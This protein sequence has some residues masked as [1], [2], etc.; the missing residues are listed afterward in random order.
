MEKFNHL[1]WSS[2]AWTS[3]CVKCVF[4]KL[5]TT[6]RSPLEKQ[7]GPAKAKLTM[8]AGSLGYGAPFFVETDFWKIIHN[9]DVKV[10]LYLSTRREG[11]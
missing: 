4:K 5:I 7:T 6:I 3:G 2:N 8:A 10:V 9:L 1:T 11:V